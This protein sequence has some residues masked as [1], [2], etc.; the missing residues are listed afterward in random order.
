MNST[1]FKAALTA[2]PVVAISEASPITAISPFVEVAIDGTDYRLDLSE[3]ITEAEKSE[4]R[5]I[6]ADWQD[7]QEQNWEAFINA[8]AGISGFYGAIA[9]SSM[10]SIITARMTRLANGEE[11]K[12]GSDP[13]LQTWNVAPPALDASQRDQLTALAET[14]GIPLSI[15]ASNILLSE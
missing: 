10:A 15:N 4:I 11:F 12:N 5:A 13:L 7:P 3:E 6:A 14:H 8:V 1:A 2:Y 9:D